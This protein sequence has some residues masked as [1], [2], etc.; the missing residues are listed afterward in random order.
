MKVLFNRHIFLLIMFYVG[1]VG[2][3]SHDDSRDTRLASECRVLLSC[4]EVYK[5]E[6]RALPTTLEEA[7]KYSSNNI[8]GKFDLKK[9]K[10]IISE[11][12]YILICRADPRSVVVSVGKNSVRV[13]DLSR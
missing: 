8:K 5:K 13:A 9:W 4:I 3:S 10:Y 12:D 1:G 7:Y 11:E 2:C 6:K